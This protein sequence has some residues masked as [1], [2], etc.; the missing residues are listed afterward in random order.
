MPRGLRRRLEVM[1]HMA[2]GR[3][4]G[5]VNVNRLVAQGLVLGSGVYIGQRVHLDAGH[6]WLITIG[7]GT[8]I[9]SGSVVLTHDGATQIPTGLTRIAPVV[10]GKRVFVGAGAVILPGARIGDDSIIGSLTV[11]RG[12]IPPGSIVVGNPGQIV[13]TVDQFAERHLRA[14]D[15]GPVWPQDGW[16][17]G[18][19][20]DDAR[21]T[22]QRAALADGASGYLRVRPTPRRA[23]PSAPHGQPPH[24][25]DRR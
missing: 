15:N 5:E 12:E 1:K 16:M 21:K 18:R 25:D 6:P 8:V 11:V 23:T 10:I 9:T 13:S 2:V 3:L 7:D 4:R 22:A 17:A 24:Q 20:I 14:A 19:G